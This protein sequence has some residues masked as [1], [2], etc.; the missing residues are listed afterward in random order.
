M[1]ARRVAGAGR[2][3]SGAPAEVVDSAEFHEVAQA[4]SWASSAGWNLPKRRKQVG[5]MRIRA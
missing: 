3:A 2:R 1:V 5:E 4:S